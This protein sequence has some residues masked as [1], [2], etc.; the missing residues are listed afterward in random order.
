M[1]KAC[2][3]F[4]PSGERFDKCHDHDDGDDGADDD[5]GDDDCLSPVVL[6]IITVIVPTPTRDNHQIAQE[7]SLKASRLEPRLS[8]VASTRLL[9]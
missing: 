9:T 3:V 4:R 5:G 6:T 8:R 1:A 2:R 7:N